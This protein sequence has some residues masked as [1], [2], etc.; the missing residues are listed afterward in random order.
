[1]CVGHLVALIH[2]IEEK[3]E[4]LGSVEKAIEWLESYKYHLLSLAAED[5]ERE[6]F[7]R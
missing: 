6:L 2:R 3:L 5:L 4:E 7:K 1:M